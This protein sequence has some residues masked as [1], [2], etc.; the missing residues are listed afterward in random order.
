MDGYEFTLADTALT[1]LPA[2]ALWLPAARA[3]AVSDL[4]LCKSERIARREGRLTPPYESQ[5]TLD[6][7][8]ALVDALRPATVICLGDSFDDGPAAA[9]LPEAA[10]ETLARLMAGRRWIWIAGNHDPGPSFLGG[11]HMAEFALGG[12]IFR[13]VAQAGAQ[14]EVSGHYHPKLRLRGR[15]PCFLVDRNRA[16]LPAFGLYTGGLDVA[17]PAFEAL[18]GDEALALVAGP[19]IAPVPLG[20]YRGRRPARLRA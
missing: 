4:H 16:I 2:G 10:A 18:F 3:L 5:E 17:A 7:L 6:R 12:L 11:A 15:R 13:H 8:A 20:A 9:A 19:R 1:A 14:A